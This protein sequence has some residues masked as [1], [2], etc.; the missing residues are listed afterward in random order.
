MRRRWWPWSL[1]LFGRVG[2]ICKGKKGLLSLW[3]SGSCEVSQTIVRGEQQ[4]NKGGENQRIPWKLWGH[5]K[6]EV[7]FKW[8]SLKGVS[9]PLLVE[10]SF[11]R[12]SVQFF[13]W[14]VSGSCLRCVG[15]GLHLLGLYNKAWVSHRLFCLLRCQFYMQRLPFSTS[16]S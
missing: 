11:L 9:L 10:R 3:T 4:E 7:S 14:L 12:S 5:H 1:I 2:I 6:R 15:L 8:I 16:F 13:Q